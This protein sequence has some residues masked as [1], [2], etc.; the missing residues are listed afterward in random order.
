MKI[1]HNAKSVRELIERDFPA[2]QQLLLELLED[3]EAMYRGELLN[4][5]PCQVPYH[6]IGHVYAVFTVSM[7]ILL[8]SCRLREQRPGTDEVKVL[9]CAALFHDSGYLKRDG[10]SGGRGGQYTFEHVEISKQLAQQYLADKPGWSTRQRRLVA[11]LIDAT[12]LGAADELADI[13]APYRGLD[14][15]LASADLLAQVSDEQ[16]VD[17][18]AH[19]YAEFVEAYEYHGLEQLRRD[20]FMVF[21]SYRHLLETSAD[22]IRLSV[23]PRLE[24]M[25]NHE[26]SLQAYFGCAPSPYMQQLQ[27]NLARLESVDSQPIC[28]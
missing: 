16:Y 22:F 18:L 6:N 26:R 5:Q 21:D 27:I 1:E 17:N 10:E 11:L 8:G 23:L 28:C 20:G 15:M 12:M 24:K 7:Q 9:A 2:Q 14:G 25:G 4:R 13:E 3:V 19:L